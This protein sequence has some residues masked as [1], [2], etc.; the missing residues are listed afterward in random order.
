MSFI[1]VSV[2]VVCVDMFVSIRQDALFLSVLCGVPDAV[3]KALQL[4]SSFPPSS[5]P[6]SWQPAVYW[7]FLHNSADERV[8]YRTLVDMYK[9][10]RRFRALFLFCDGVSVASF[11]VLVI[12]LSL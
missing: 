8:A 12:T 9:V 2:Y 6:S 3:E 10:S 5:L 11:L 1:L 4:A 7:A